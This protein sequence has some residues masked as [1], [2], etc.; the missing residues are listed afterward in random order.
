MAIQWRDMDL[1]NGLIN[2]HRQL[3]PVT[4]GVQIKDTLKTGKSMRQ[5]G[6]PD[7]IIETLKLCKAKHDAA[8]EDPDT[9]FFDTGDDD[10][11]AP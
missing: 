6:I 11:L 9:E 4:G 2:V 10:Y 1:D 3:I 5:V 7:K 8:K